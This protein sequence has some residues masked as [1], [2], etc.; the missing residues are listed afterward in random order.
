M[1]NVLFTAQSTRFLVNWEEL[2]PKMNTIKNFKN[3]K[4]RV[5]QKTS[6]T[7]ACVIQPIGQ[8]ESEQKHGCNDQTSSN[9]SMYRVAD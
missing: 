2:H 9:V 3:A 1:P 5:A 7:F 4:Y 8:Y 6:Q